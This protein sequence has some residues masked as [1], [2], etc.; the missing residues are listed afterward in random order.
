[1]R[2]PGH[3][4]AFQGHAKTPGTFQRSSDKWMH[5]ESPHRRA[6]QPGHCVMCGVTGL[7]CKGKVSISPLALSENSYRELRCS[8]CGTQELS[9]MISGAPS[10]PFSLARAY[11]LLPDTSSGFIRFIQET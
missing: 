1:M 6:E 3:S 5:G 4:K 9:L 11:V 7:G 2:L 10:S 8:A